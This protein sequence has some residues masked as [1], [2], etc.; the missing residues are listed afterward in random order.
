MGNRHHVIQY[1]RN[2]SIRW[3]EEP[4]LSADEQLALSAFSPC[5]IEPSQIAWLADHSRRMLAKR[6]A[7]E[8]LQK[9]GQKKR[10]ENFSRG[11]CLRGKFLNLS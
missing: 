3:P 9:L 10:P 2:E 1:G 6:K 8:L 7:I 11:R 4:N 5:E